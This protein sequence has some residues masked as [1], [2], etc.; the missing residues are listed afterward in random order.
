MCDN[1]SS[2][3]SFICYYL[4]LGFATLLLYVDDPEDEA[5]AVAS[6][7]PAGRVQV[8]TH[9]ESLREEWRQLPSWQRLRLYAETEVQARQ[10]LNAEHAMDRALGLGMHFLLHVDSDELLHLPSAA[11]GDGGRALQEHAALLERRGALQFTYRNLEAVPEREACDDPFR[12]VTLFKQHPSELHERE[13]KPAVREALE[14]WC[15]AEG[16]GGKLFRFYSNGK[17][18]VRVHDAMRAAET[19]HEFRLPREGK[20]RFVG[21]FTNN[22][23]L[24]ESAYVP[25]TQAAWEEAGGAVLLHF[26]VCDFGL[27]WRKRWAALGYASPNHRFRGGSGGLDQRAHLLATSARRR[28]TPL[29]PPAAH[30][31]R[32]QPAPPSPLAR[33]AFP[34]HRA[35]RTRPWRCTVAP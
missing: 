16:G 6:R 20:G 33:P 13:G 35:G 28:H 9:D 26:A 23:Q 27:F 32:L 10:Q 3:D 22:R 25:H 30:A 34:R 14:H 12:A 8:R 29:H 7:Y 15:R 21:G 5:V 1:A 19:V 2:L 4:E 24:R 17:S 31:S 18:L 11:M